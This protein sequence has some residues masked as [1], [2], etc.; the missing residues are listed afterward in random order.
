MNTEEILKTILIYLLIS[1]LIF[2]SGLIPS[3]EIQGIKILPMLLS[4]LLLT[5]LLIWYCW[6]KKRDNQVLT[7]TTE[8]YVWQIVLLLFA[9]AMMVR[10]PMVLILGM[11]FEKTPVI[12]LTVLTIILI[13]RGKLSDFGFKTE[14]FSWAL[15]T[16]LAYYMIFG[17][18][19]FFTFFSSVYI[20]TGQFII[21]EFSI[22]YSLALFPFM[23]L[24]VGLS[25]ESLFRGFMQT[26]LTAIFSEKK[27]L[28]IQ[29]MLFGIW[30][31]VWHISPINLI[32]MISHV[33]ITFFFGLVFG[34]FYKLSKNLTPLILAHGLV[35]AIPYGIISYPEI[36]PT[37][38][39]VESSQ[40]L[41][42]LAS[43][44]ILYLSVKFISKRKPLN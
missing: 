37:G 28:L 43:L 26:H 21:P 41:S 31:I 3:G 39:V 29:A 7:H 23:T 12:F 5:P 40:L 24:C 34:V 2:V 35:D 14:R 15:F 20:Y 36:E 11:S 44:S 33:V 42:F 32:G 16:G 6:Y 13:E 38:F 30:H 18:T 8:G 1:A 4:L 10:F 22:L 25:E 17:V 27:A 9:L 19:W